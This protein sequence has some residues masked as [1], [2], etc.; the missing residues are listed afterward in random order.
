ML[1]AN[2]ARCSMSNSAAGSHSVAGAEN[3]PLRIFAMAPMVKGMRPNSSDIT[4]GPAMEPSRPFTTT[5]VT[6][7]EVPKAAAAMRAAKRRA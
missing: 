6:P 2:W 1:T 5:R 7:T 4:V 3:S